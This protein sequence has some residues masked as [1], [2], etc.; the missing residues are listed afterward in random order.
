M[1]KITSNEGKPYAE[2]GTLL[3]NLR[4]RRGMSQFD[5]A[6]ASGINNSYLSRIENGERR[7]SPK[8]LKRFS[9]ILQFPYD[10]LV[11]T[12]GI[13]SEDFVKSTP[14]EPSSNDPTTHALQQLISGIQGKPAGS[15]GSS[16]VA[17]ARRAMPVYDTVPAGLLK[18]ANVVEAHADV[19]KLVLSEEEMMF[20]PNSFGLIVQGDSMLEAGILD[21]DT[22]IVSPASQVNNGDIAVVQVNRRQTTV[23]KVYFE[24][25][26]VILQP[27]NHNYRPQ[28]LKYPDEVEIL[29]RVILVRRKLI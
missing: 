17:T 18:D 7:P 16:A 4:L 29:G 1:P 25:D 10:E 8:I 14:S 9:E 5:L 27:A 28:V 15:N 20:D 6:D 12:S 26:S 21:G 22:L 3:R 11:V 2:I 19:E 24:N 13:L 23:K